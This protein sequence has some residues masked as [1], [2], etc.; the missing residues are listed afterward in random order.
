MFVISSPPSAIVVIATVMMMSTSIDEVVAASSLSSSTTTSTPTPA[1]TFGS[2]FAA[3][4]AVLFVVMIPVTTIAVLSRLRNEEDNNHHRKQLRRTTSSSRAAIATTNNNNKTTKNSSNKKNSAPHGPPAAAA[5]SGGRS[6]D[7]VAKPHNAILPVMMNYKNVNKV[8]LAMVF[9]T[10]L[11]VVFI[12][13]LKNKIFS[14]AFFKM[15]IPR[16]HRTPT[17]ATIDMAVAAALGVVGLTVGIA[18]VIVVWID[19]MF[20]DVCSHDRNGL[21]TTMNRR[22]DVKIRPRPKKKGK[23]TM[24]EYRVRYKKKGWKEPGR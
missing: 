19:K 15:M 22:C 13:G 2:L 17:D 3:A 8:G 20:G 11:L 24:M 12:I 21:I 9:L 7:N 5:T 1:T 10:L 23:L 6:K 14:I 4:T 18:K 16:I